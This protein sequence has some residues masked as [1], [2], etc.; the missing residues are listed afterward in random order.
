MK[1]SLR[2]AKPYDQVIL[3]FLLERNAKKVYVSEKEVV[4]RLSDEFGEVDRKLLN[5]VLM[6]MEIRGLILVQS[7]DSTKLISLAE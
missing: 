7:K 5:R 1:G 6:R 2:V 4:D 3:E